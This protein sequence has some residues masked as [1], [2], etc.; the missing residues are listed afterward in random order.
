MAL[1]ASAIK[2]Q[3]KS[4]LTPFLFEETEEEE[5]VYIPITIKGYGWH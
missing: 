1:E 5:F 2:D 4:L 3:F